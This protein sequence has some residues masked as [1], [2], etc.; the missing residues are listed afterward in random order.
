MNRLRLIASIAALFVAGAQAQ[1]VVLPEPSNRVRVAFYNVENLFDTEDDPLT[2]D[3]EFLPEG[4]YQWTTYRYYKKLDQISKV[5]LNMGGWTVPGIIGMCEIENRR[6]LEDLL[7]FTGLQKFEYEIVH[8]D[9]P[10]ARGIDVALLYR[11]DIFRYLQHDIIRIRMP[12]DTATKTRDVLYMSGIVAGD[13]LHVFV[14]HWPSR[15]GGQEASQPKRVY[16][17]E[18]VR[19]KVDSI[20]LLNSN[21]QIIV[22]GDLNDGPEDK[23]VSEALRAASK[24]DQMES[25]G[26]FNA[27]HA[28]RFKKGLGSHKYQGEWNALDHIILSSGLL[29]SAN[30]VY[31]LPEDVV[32][33]QAPWLMEDDA[34]APGQKPFRTYL[35]PR[36]I[37][38]F[39]D[40]LPV[41]VD[42]RV[43]PKW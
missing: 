17:A 40:H 35:G 10:D 36:Y 26:L 25:P 1:D 43:R 9:S 27:M 28:L 23:S 34:Q 5:F 18:Q 32:I 24:S 31:A 15:R 14:N 22:M 16:V 33:F 30:T 7:R 11:P 21:A 6:V 20:F 29:D 19:L 8:E 3:E 42:L 13:T 12:F 39:S 2:W 37:G 41:Y 4:S 38:G